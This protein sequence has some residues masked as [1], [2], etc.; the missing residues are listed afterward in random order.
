[1]QLHVRLAKRFMWAVVDTVHS[2]RVFS[3]LP[4]FLKKKLHFRQQWKQQ[5]YKISSPATVVSRS[6]QIICREDFSN[7]ILSFKSFWCKSCWT[8]W[9][10]Y[11]L[12]TQCIFF[13]AAR[14][15]SSHIWA[16][17]QDMSSTSRSLIFHGSWERHCPLW[18][19][20]PRAQLSSFSHGGWH[21]KRKRILLGSINACTHICVLAGS[22]LFSVFLSGSVWGAERV[23]SYLRWN[24][25][26]W[27]SV[28]LFVLGGLSLTL[29]AP[30]AISS[31]CTAE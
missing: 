10:S 2:S 26:C 11:P 24:P 14:R 12:I 16:D 28:A 20:S 6:L 1:M 31:I 25:T 22:P 3:E 18:E 29:S 17:S 8:A 19:L 27:C 30:H 21:C 13:S 9:F 4:C 23:G 15:E 5:Q 7:W